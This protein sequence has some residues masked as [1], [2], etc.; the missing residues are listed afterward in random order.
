MNLK[1]SFLK[2][3]KDCLRTNN[4]QTL[5]ETLPNYTYYPLA[6]DELY[7]V[8]FGYHKIKNFIQSNALISQTKK[9][10]SDLFLQR[11]YTRLEISNYFFLGHWVH[12]QIRV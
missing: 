7:L 1:D 4:L 9:S 12:H 5:S 3:I 8:C 6:K 2:I 10:V 11:Q